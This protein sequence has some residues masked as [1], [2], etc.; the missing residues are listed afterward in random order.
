MLLK[1]KPAYHNHCQLV[2][3]TGPNKAL[4]IWESTIVGFV[5]T[6]T[7]ATWIE[8]QKEKQRDFKVV[9]P[10]GFSQQR[11]LNIWG[12][13]YD[14]NYFRYLFFSYSDQKATN[15][16]QSVAY[17]FNLPNWWL[18]TSKTFL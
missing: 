6:K 7:L 16:F 1:L 17:I 12:N 11:L 2:L 5:P 10:K 13:S 8:Q 3:A 18:A 14:A 4:V 15:C 9:N